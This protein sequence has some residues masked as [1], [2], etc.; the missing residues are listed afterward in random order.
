MCSTPPTPTDA[1]EASILL[2]KAL[3]GRER[4]VIVITKTGLFMHHR[5][6]VQAAMM[7]QLGGLATVSVRR[8]RLPGEILHKGDVSLRNT[9][10]ERS[11]L[12]NGGSEEA[13]RRLPAA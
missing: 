6:V 8:P 10:F 5:G 4:D 9:W 13:T 1:V 12:V 3:K 7:H 2:G 11:Q